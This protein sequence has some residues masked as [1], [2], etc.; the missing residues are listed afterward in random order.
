VPLHLRNAPTKLMKKSGYGRDYKYAH[1][2]EG[3]FALQDFLPQEIAG[4][5]LYDPQNN[6]RENEL[7][8]RLR[9]LWGKKYKY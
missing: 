8:A 1:D 2:F 6:P 3:N 7:R 5:I 4:S 9:Q